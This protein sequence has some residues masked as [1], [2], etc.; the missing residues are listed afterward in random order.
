MV[1]NERAVVSCMIRGNE[2]VWAVVAPILEISDFTDNAMGFLYQR[3][4]TRWQDGQ[5]VDTVTLNDDMAQAGAPERED[6]LRAL[7]DGIGEIGNAK[8]YAGFVYRDSMLRLIAESA[9]AQ[10]QWTTESTDF[11]GV[12][13]GAQAS[14][15]SISERE[16]QRETGRISDILIST[17]EA[18]AERSLAERPLGF[19]TGIRRYDE[20][21]DGLRRKHIHY[22]SAYT[23]VGKSWIAIASTVGFLR[24]GARVQVHT[25]EMSAEQYLIRLC[26]YISGVDSWLIER[27][28]GSLE[29]RMEIE[30]AQDWIGAQP[31]RLYERQSSVAG[32]IRLARFERPDI[33]ILDYIQKVSPDSA[34]EQRYDILTTAGRRIAESA[35]SI[36]MGW[37]ILS[38]VS[39]EQ[40]ALKGAGSEPHMKGSGDLAA[41]ADFHTELYRDKK[42]EPE[43]LKMNHN[44][45]R[46]GPTG[47]AEYRFDLRHGGMEYIRGGF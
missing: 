25:L 45:N 7:V 9:T 30:R 33:G 43:I 29:Q 5:A 8:E 36:N 34:N 14:L 18:I 1:Q 2:K 22:L 46:H 4:I 38:Q 44:K 13:A 28:K 17:R 35:K 11:R 3:I 27:G 15:D 24:D 10:G 31:L 16:G 6:V 47:K 32:M 42:N 12:L 20:L 21:A 37:L 41:D 40:A 39:N 26:A 23:S 19:T